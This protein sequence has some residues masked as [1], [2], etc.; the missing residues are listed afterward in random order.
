MFVFK[1]LILSLFPL[2]TRIDDFQSKTG[3]LEAKMYALQLKFSVNL[4]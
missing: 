1:A 3:A 2:E 4:L